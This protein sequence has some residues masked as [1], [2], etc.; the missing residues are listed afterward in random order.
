MDDQSEAGE[1][2]HLPIMY[3]ANLKSEFDWVYHTV[4]QKNACFALKEKVRSI[5]GII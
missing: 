2:A 4:P 5:T 3:L 1:T